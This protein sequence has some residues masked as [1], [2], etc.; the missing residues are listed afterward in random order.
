VA[1]TWLVECE[2]Q[3]FWADEVALAVFLKHLIDA[4]EASEQANAPWL[5]VAVSAWRTVACIPA[6]G[7]SFDDS[8]FEEQCHT[9]VS[10]AKQACARLSLRDSISPEEIAEWQ[11]HE[12]LR[13]FPPGATEVRTAPVVELG[14][15]IIALVRGELS[16]A[17][18]GQ[19]WFYGTPAG[20]QTLK[21]GG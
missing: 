10:L 15:A 8:W 11:I 1:A 17:P 3:G 12:D 7:L 6:F 9:F 16:Q 14:R 4:A 19:S 18:V 2:G 5:V 20:R 21:R 13:I